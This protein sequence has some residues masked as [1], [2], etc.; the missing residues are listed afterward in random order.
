MRRV[1]RQAPLLPPPHPKENY[2]LEEGY[3]QILF[4]QFLHPRPLQDYYLQRCNHRQGTKACSPASTRWVFR[5]HRSR[6]CCP[7]HQSHRPHH[8]LRSR[9]SLQCLYLR[10]RY[11]L[12]G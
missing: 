6:H 8:G 4:H 2:L 10:T 3:L 11:Q 9:Q 12:A 7:S 5:H 1:Y